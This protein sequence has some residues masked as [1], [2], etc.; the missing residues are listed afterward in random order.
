[1]VVVDMLPHH[2]HKCV[3][4]RAN[5][6]CGFQIDR[7]KE[8]DRERK[9]ERQRLTERG[10]DRDRGR[11]ERERERDRDRGRERERGREGGREEEHPRRNECLFES[12]SCR[13]CQVS[14]PG[15]SGM[16][17]HLVT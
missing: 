10:R 6:C 11:K 16:P 5:H 1:M 8:T 9:R 7:E 12:S 14:L 13:P 15:M 2:I 3:D 17:G 4:I